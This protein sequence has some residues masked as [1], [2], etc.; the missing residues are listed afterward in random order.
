MTVTSVAGSVQRRRMRRRGQ[1]RNGVEEEKRG[2]G[3]RLAP[4]CES[5]NLLFSACGGS[6]SGQ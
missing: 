5:T 6:I 4:I 3:L 2:L 1:S